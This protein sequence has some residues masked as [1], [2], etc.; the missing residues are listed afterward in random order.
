MLVRADLHT[1]STASDGTST[2]QEVMHAAKAAGLDVVALTDHD[3]SAGWAPALRAAQEV[4]LV[5]VPGAEISSR[6][7]G[8]SVHVLSYLHDPTHPGL[9]EVLERSRTSRERRARA[10]ADLIGRDYPLTWDDV[11]AHT[12]PGA[13]VGRPHLAD[14]LVA[15]GVGGSRDE[16]FA[17]ILR[18]RGRYDVPYDAPSPVEAVRLVRAAGGVAVVA[19]PRGRSAPLSDAAIAELA[20]AGLQGIE[21]DH[22]DHD[23]VTRDALRGLA[24]DLGLFVTGSSDYHGWGKP[25]LVGENLT[26]PVVVEQILD[27]AGRT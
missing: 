9:R 25:N 1:H 27:A 15:N 2:P 14:A 6:A 10:M 21:V 13:T 22:R 16:V 11:L 8:A 17:D 20:A 23:E 4:G 12:P 26:A 5:L 7:R 24:V 18:D 19:H 3:T